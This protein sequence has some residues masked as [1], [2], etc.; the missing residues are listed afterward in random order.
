MKTGTILINAYTQSESELYQPKRLKEALEKLGVCVQIKRNILS[1]GLCKSK[2]EIQPFGD[3]CVYLDKDRYAGELL[4]RA[5]MRLFNR[6]SAVA[7]CDDKMATFSALAGEGIPFPDSYFAPLCYSDEP[8]SEELLEGVARKLGFPLVVKTC[9]GS[10]GKGVYLAEGREELFALA[11]RLQGVPHL[12]QKFVASSRGRDVR[13]IVIGGEA[14]VAMLRTSDGDFRS[15]IELGGKGEPFPLDGA[16]KEL[17]AKV[18]RSLRLDYC[19]IDFL[20]DGRGGYTVCEVNSNAFFGGMERVTGY[21]VA[22]E[23]AKYIVKEGC[24]T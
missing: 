2:V 20:F 11:S 10:L 21:P 4:E 23:Y 14:R 8:V 6:A 15:N 18:A 1:A 17:G 9:Y 13:V 19:G 16:L 3:F 12:F 7:V 22:E 5:G 24:G